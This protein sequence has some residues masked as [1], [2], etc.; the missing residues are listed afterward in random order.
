M[1]ASRLKRIGSFMHIVFL[2]L[3]DH[4]SMPEYV[5]NPPNP[6]N[7]NLMKL[8]KAHNIST[9]EELY[10]RADSDPEWFW[11]AVIEDCGIVF[12]SPYST[13][14]DSAKGVPWSTWFNG[15]K[16]NVTYNCVEKFKELDEPAVKYERENGKSGT[17]TFRELDN[18]TGKLAGSLLKLG[19][20]KGDRIG[21]YMPPSPES[22]IALY[23]I[24]RIGAVAVPIFSGYGLDAVRTRV[25]DAGITYIFSISSYERKGKIIDVRKVLSGLSGTRIIVAGD[26]RTNLLNFHELV[27]DGDYTPSVDTNSEDP[28]IMLYTS[29]T[30]GKPKG[31]VHVH[32]GSFINIAKEVRYYMDMTR[33]DTLFWISDLGWM[34]GPWSI[35]GANAIGGSIFV[36]DGAV[37]YPKVDRLWD[38]IKDHSITLLGLSP[39]LVRTLRS[40]GIGK[41][42]DGLRVFGSTGEPWDEESWMWLFQKLGGGKVPIANIS[43]GTD[44]IG[45]FLASTPAI[46]LMPRCLYKGLGMNVSVLD[47]NGN[48]VYDKVGYLVAKKHCPSM[49][50]GIWKQPEKYVDAYW[51]KFPGNWAQ[52]DWAT[53]DKK[54]Y[55]FLYGR[56]DDVLKVAGKRLGPNEVE[57]IVMNVAGV[58]ESAV[59]G[60]PDEIKGEAVAVFYTGTNDDR[61]RDS[62]KKA[63][64]DGLGKSFSPKYVL[65]LPQLPKTR[66]GKI[67]RRVV[68]KA[69]L[70]EDPGDLSNMED[71]GVIDYIRELGMVYVRE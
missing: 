62:I 53:M 2:H 4:I 52:G 63:V 65:W 36:Y 55:Y 58:T 21:I 22:V 59:S 7:S 50:R 27:K 39:T 13:L 3:H 41:E 44:I 60:I 49:T 31:T 12:N 16:I 56:S 68:R 20:R 25:E 1:N 46:P 35:L 9:V 71:T 48:E 43:G 17:I 10:E 37:D 34:M 69:F 29:G 67:M 28:A 8:A 61:T 54:G 38:L 11:P 70:N 64:S 45:C 30:T 33:E 24:M 5:Y 66:N 6:S 23:S 15:G 19:V 57:N 42:F 32:G 18:K 14:V 26:E 40:K 47:E 51:S